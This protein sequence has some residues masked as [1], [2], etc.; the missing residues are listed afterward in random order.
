MSI[1]FYGDSATV[2]LYML[3]SHRLE[4]I[5]TPKKTAYSFFSSPKKD[6]KKAQEVSF[7][8]ERELERIV[9]NY[10]SCTLDNLDENDFFTIFEKDHVRHGLLQEHMCQ[11]LEK[12][13]G[14]SI[15][16]I[17]GALVPWGNGDTGVLD[18]IVISPRG[19]ATIVTLQLSHP[20]YLADP[21]YVDRM[22][23]AWHEVSEAINSSQALSIKPDVII[24]NI[25]TPTGQASLIPR[26]FV[27]HI[28][29][30][31][32]E[33]DVPVMIVDHSDV[34]PILSQLDS[35]NE[36]DAE[37]FFTQSN[38]SVLQPYR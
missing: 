18:H 29:K 27:N 8:N 32:E 12:L 21:G 23:I 7:A 28:S 16:V 31:L 25:L 5:P 19:I 1:T 4:D 24:V 33:I 34:L 9:E 30:Q 20:L 38:I 36:M 37:Q 10:S 17:N 35:P 13:S 6:K 22:Q 26:G 3:A 11:D 15:E 14:D 2:P